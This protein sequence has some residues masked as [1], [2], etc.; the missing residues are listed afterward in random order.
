MILTLVRWA[1][2]AWAWLIR[3][4]HWA[5][6]LFPIG[7]LLFLSRKRDVTVISPELH[8]ADAVKEKIEEKVVEQERKA[9]KERE[10]SV[11]EA[12]E[13]HAQ[14]LSDLL[15]AQQRTVQTI[16]GKPDDLTKAMLNSG[17]KARQ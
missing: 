10:S 3:D 2:T 7:I 15:H 9:E 16:E 4:Y 8:K 6:V 5:Y 13:D 1:R 12:Q 14:N 11:S 17:K